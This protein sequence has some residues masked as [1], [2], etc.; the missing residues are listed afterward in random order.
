MFTIVALSTIA[1]GIGVNVVMFSI[2]NAVLLRPLPYPDA[3][4]LLWLTGAIQ[5]RGLPPSPGRSDFKRP[6][7]RVCRGDSL[8][9]AA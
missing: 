3:D 9:R 2:T 8:L 1:L 4:R 6:R 7:P 5:S